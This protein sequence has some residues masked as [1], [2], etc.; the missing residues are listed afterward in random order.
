M[1]HKQMDLK[2]LANVAKAFVADLFA[3][4]R[5]FSIRLEAATPVAKTSKWNITVSFLREPPSGQSDAIAIFALAGDR[6]FKVVTI[7]EAT[8]TVISVKDRE[9]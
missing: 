5:P 6:S 4:E 1:D 7:D 8:D 3:D 9:L 2:H